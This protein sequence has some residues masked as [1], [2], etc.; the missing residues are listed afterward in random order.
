MLY[1]T[2]Q[3]SLKINLKNNKNTTLYIIVENMGRLNFGNDLLD[4]KVNL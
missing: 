1:R 3:T 4:S 2:G